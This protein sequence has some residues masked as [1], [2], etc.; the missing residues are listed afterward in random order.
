MSTSLLKK[1]HLGLNEFQ[2]TVNKNNSE[3]REYCIF[4]C[5]F[6]YSYSR[7]YFNKYLYLYLGTYFR[8]ITGILLEYFFVTLFTTAENT[9]TSRHARKALEK[10]KP[11]KN[12][13]IKVIMLHRSTNTSVNSNSPLKGVVKFITMTNNSKL[14]TGNGK[15]R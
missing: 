8:K 15:G 10:D 13:F 2:S 5:V 4:L 1:N 11:Y 9:A 12:A 14:V 6:F 3:K 7:S